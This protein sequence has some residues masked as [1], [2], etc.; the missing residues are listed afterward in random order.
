MMTYRVVS[1]KGIEAI[2]LAEAPR[3]VPGPGMVLVELRAASLNYRD[4]LVA[5]GGYPL[6]DR[7]P[8]VPLSDGAGIIA[9]VG[10]GV[11]RW[12]VGDR[13]VANFMQ[14]WIAGGPTPE[15]LASSLGGGVD[16]VLAEAFVAPADALVPIPAHLEFAEASTLPCA[17]LTAWNALVAAGTRAGQTVLT[18]GTGG[19]SIFAVQFARAMGATPIITS[20]SDAKLDAAR[21]HG[22]AHG[23]NYATH[24]DWHEQVRTLTGGRGVDHVIETGG[25]GTLEQSMLSVAI[26]GTVSLIGVLAQG[27]PPAMTQAL[28]RCLTVRGIYVGSVEMFEA[29]NRAIVVHALRPVID[30]RYSFAD[31]LSAYRAF[32]SQR[33]VGKIV[34]VRD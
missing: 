8:V 13:A 19:V 16:G 30:T 1:D 11:T 29:M 21:S 20:S 18:L 28:L 10:P 6:N 17:A 15:A 14:R 9:A 3:P 2:E 12:K 4:V 32:E 34:I 25:P 7:R 5:R 27:S 23:I 33:H 22:A 26:G 31:A 24:P